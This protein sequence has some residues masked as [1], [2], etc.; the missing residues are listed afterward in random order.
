VT[1]PPLRPDSESG[2]QFDIKLV[3]GPD[4]SVAIG[5]IA[6]MTGNAAGSTWSRLTQTGPRQVDF[7][8]MH[9]AF[10]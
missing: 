8:V 3:S 1:K 4:I 5:G 6:D 10:R 2:K 7:A 9:C